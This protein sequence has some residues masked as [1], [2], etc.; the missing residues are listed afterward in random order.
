MN[1]KK[2]KQMNKNKILEYFLILLLFI[3]YL[4][5]IIMIKMNIR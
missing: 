3:I 1:I 5:I 4:F 2:S